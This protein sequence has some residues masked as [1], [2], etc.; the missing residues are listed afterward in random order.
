MRLSSR[1]VRMSLQ[2]A[3]SSVSTLA[4]YAEMRPVFSSSPFCASLFSMEPMMRGAAGAHNVL[5]RNRE[6]V[7][8]L[9]AQVLGRVLRHLLHVL[10]HLLVALGLLGELGHVDIVGAGH[11]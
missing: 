6:Q 2:M 10:N 4:L 5:V 8:L 9:E 1:S 7:A 11:C 3:L